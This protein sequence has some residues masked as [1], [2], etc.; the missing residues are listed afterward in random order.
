MAIP[1]SPT[2]PAAGRGRDSALVGPEHPLY[3]SLARIVPIDLSA[4][5][6]VTYAAR[7]ADCLPGMLCNVHQALVEDIGTRAGEQWR[8]TSLS[9][10]TIQLPAITDT[11]P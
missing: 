9:D 8:P 1:T 4:A 10:A 7:C 3:E 6:S 5:L 11:T 2:P